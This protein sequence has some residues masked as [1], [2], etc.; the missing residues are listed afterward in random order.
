MAVS[1]FKQVQGLNSAWVYAAENP[2]G[3]SKLSSVCI[4]KHCDYLLPQL[5]SSLCFATN[6]PF[7]KVQE[8][9][10]T[11]RLYSVDAVP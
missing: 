6:K 2:P 1:D 10:G 3:C 8:L 5:W 7:L 9:I 4:W 11:Q